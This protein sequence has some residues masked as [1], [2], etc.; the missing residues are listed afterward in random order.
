MNT[1]LIPLGVDRLFPFPG[2]LPADMSASITTW[3][4][5]D[6]TKVDPKID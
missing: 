5:F 2:C 3:V 4:N 6:Y 1:G